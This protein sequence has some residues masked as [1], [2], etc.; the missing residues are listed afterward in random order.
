MEIGLHI[1]S[2]MDDDLGKMLFTSVAPVADG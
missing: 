2:S 1:S